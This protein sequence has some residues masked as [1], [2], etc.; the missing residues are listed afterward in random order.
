M[1]EPQLY[2]DEDFRPYPD[3]DGAE[4][5]TSRDAAVAHLAQHVERMNAGNFLG[6]RH[7]VAQ[8]DPSTFRVIAERDGSAYSSTEYTLHEVGLNA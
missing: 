5:F 4:A 8:S 3:M 7:R 1:V 6:L 2:S